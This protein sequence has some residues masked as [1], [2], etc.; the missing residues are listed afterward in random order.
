MLFSPSFVTIFTSFAYCSLFLIQYS[1]GL[2]WYFI[3]SK[4]YCQQINIVSYCPTVWYYKSI[5]PN[6]RVMSNFC[7]LLVGKDFRCICWYIWCAQ[8][9]YFVNLCDFGFVFGNSVPKLSPVMVWV[10]HYFLWHLKPAKLYWIYGG[11][12]YE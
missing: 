2:Y 6:C 4:S 8:F 5:V 10:V 3:K 7:K 11:F 12:D 9:L 1:Y